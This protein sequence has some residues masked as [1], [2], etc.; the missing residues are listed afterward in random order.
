MGSIL[1]GMSSFGLLF[2]RNMLLFL[3]FQVNRMLARNFVLRGGP[4]QIV[5]GLYTEISN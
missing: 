5:L 1:A 2:L 3:G 4:W